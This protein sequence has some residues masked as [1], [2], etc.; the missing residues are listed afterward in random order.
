LDFLGKF[1]DVPT[2][3]FTEIHPVGSAMIHPCRRMDIKRVTD[4][5]HDYENVPK[6]AIYTIHVH[7]V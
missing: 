6:N 1:S 2:P 3:N 7:K 5:F 4:A